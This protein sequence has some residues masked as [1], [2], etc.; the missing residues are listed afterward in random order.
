MIREQTLY[1][2]IPLDHKILYPVICPWICS[3]ISWFI[4]YGNLNRISNLLLCANYINL[5][6]VELGHCAFPVYYILLLF[7]LF[8]LLIFES[9]I[10][11]LQLKLLT[12]LLKKIITIYS[13]TIC[14]FVLY[15][16]SLR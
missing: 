14:N 2:S 1:D 16:P 3:S 11:K 12:Y 15:F 4:V 10:L 13:G 6:Y 5:N 7:C 8:T 9:L